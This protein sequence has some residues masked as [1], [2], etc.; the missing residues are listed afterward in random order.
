MKKIII[1][2]I[3]ALMLVFVAASVNAAQPVLNSIGNKDAFEDTKL[4]FVVTATDTSLN[5]QTSPGHGL[6]L[7]VVGLPQ[8]ASISPNPS[9]FN[10]GTGTTATWTFTWTPDNDDLGEHTLSFN[11]SDNTS[12]TP[13][14]SETETIKIDVFPTLC[15]D[16]E[17]GNDIKISDLDLDEDEYRIGED[18]ILDVDVDNDANKDLD[19]N[20]EAFLYDVKEQ[21]EIDSFESDTVDVNDGDTE[22]FEVEMKFPFDNDLDEDGDFIIFVKAFEDGDEDSN[23]AQDSITVDLERDDNDVVVRDVRVTPEIVSPGDSVEFSVE[24]LNVGTDDQDEVSIEIVNSE[25]GINQKGNKFDLERAGDN[26]DELTQRFN[27]QIPAS[28]RAKDYSFNVR[29]LDEDGDVYDNGD[30]FATLKVAGESKPAASMSLSQQS[31]ELDAGDSF[32][33]LVNVKNAGNNEQTFIIDV[34]PSGSWASSV[35]QIVSVAGSSEKLVEIPVIVSDDAEAGSYSATVS[36]KAGSE[37]LASSNIAV[38]VKSTTGLEPVTGETVY[39][40]ILGRSTTSTIFWIIGD[41]A[42]IIIIVYFLM[43]LF[44]KKK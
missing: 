43:L 42:L 7:N 17:V 1:A 32:N 25:L 2:G 15:E 34:L 14:L 41:V 3:L 13:F 28:A 26:D 8:G 24:V 10:I 29:I 38:N 6:K 35:S 27:I 19:I 37:T 20:V 9:T 33:L 16:G 18:I 21:D 44:R 22:K 11:V 30:A 4:T 36:L 12:P 40:P 5:D 23:C 39:R 31:F